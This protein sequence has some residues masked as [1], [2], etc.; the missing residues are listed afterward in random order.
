MGKKYIKLMIVM[1]VT[2]FLI[3][4]LGSVYASNSTWWSAANNFFS[5]TDWRNQ[6]DNNILQDLKNIIKVGGNAI[7]LIVTV[8]LGIKYMA[9]SAEGKGDVKEGLTGLIIAIVLFYGWTAIDNILTRSGGSFDYW[10]NTADATTTIKNIY[11]TIVS[12]LNYVAVG[13]LIFVGVK[14][15]FAGAEGKA[16]LKGKGVPFVIGLIMTFATISFLNFLI[17]VVGDFIS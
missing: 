11:G 6:Q 17:G 2:T 10:F 14:Y 7:F 15:L 16:D 9:S 3:I 13:V 12:I 8:V 4:C 1:L 5:G